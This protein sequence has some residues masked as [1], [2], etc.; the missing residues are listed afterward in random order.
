MTFPFRDPCLNSSVVTTLVSQSGGLLRNAWQNLKAQESEVHKLALVLGPKKNTFIPKAWLTHSSVHYQAHL[1]RISDFLIPGPGKW[2][3]STEEGIEFF[4]TPTCAPI[5]HQLHHY[6]SSTL[7]DIELYL[8]SK[9]EECCAKN[10]ILPAYYIRSYKSNGDLGNISALL[11]PVNSLPQ[12]Q[13]GSLPQPQVGS[14]R[15]PQLGSLPQPQ[16]GSLPQ[17]QVGQPQVGSRQLGSLPQP[18]VGSL[19]QPQRSSLPQPQVGSLPQPQRG[20]LPQP[21][22]GSLPQPQRSSLPQPQVGSLPQP[23]RGSLPQPQ[24]GS[25]PQPQVGSLPQPQ[26]SSLPQPQLHSFP[27]PQV[28]QPIHR[29]AG[30]QINSSSEQM[31]GLKTTLAIQISEILPLEHNLQRFDYLRSQIKAAKER[32]E[33][34]SPTKQSEYNKLSNFMKQKLIHMVASYTNSLSSWLQ[35]FKSQHGHDPGN[36]DYPPALVSFPDPNN[37]SEDRLQYLAGK[38]GLVIWP[39]ATRIYGMLTIS[40]IRD[41]IS[42]V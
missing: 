14:L 42:V 36:K 34:F 23:Q 15:Q 13:L 16:L 8:H 9:W 27:Q 39:R 21:Q 24:V 30:T 17:P 20:S 18:Q 5:E 38:E 26:R 25:L 41:V 4:D 40:F 12:P 32:K 1:E 2:W 29:Q 6:R 33:Q 7:A 37:P 10:I 31:Q 35:D 3:K 19:P 22:V 11:S 28:G